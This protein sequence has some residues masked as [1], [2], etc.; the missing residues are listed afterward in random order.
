MIAESDWDDLLDS[1]EAGRVLPVLGW[2]ITTFGEQDQLLGPWLAQ[3]YAKRLRVDRSVLPAEFSVN[4]VVARHLVSKGRR[5]D[6]VPRFSDTVAMQD[7]GGLGGPGKSLLQLAEVLGLRLF[8]SLTPDSLMQQALDQVRH[9]GR[10]AT[11]VRRF[12]LQDTSEDLEVSLD[13]VSRRRSDTWVYHVLGRAAPQVGSCVIWDEDLLEFLLALNSSLERELLRNLYLALHPDQSVELLAIGVSFSDWVMRLFLRVMRQTPLTREQPA[14]RFVE[15]GSA[16]PAN[17]VLLCG[18]SVGGLQLLDMSPGEFVR[19][20]SE[21]WQRRHPVS[22]ELIPAAIAVPD[23]LPECAV[24][25]SY[26]REDQVAVAELVRRLQRRGCEVWLD[27][28]RLQSGM[29]FDM[30]IEDYIKKRRILFVSVISEQ[31]ELSGDAY[32]HKERTWAAEKASSIPEV[33]REEFYFPLIISE[34]LD[35]GRVQK[36]PRIFAGVHRERAAGGCVT[37]QFCDRLRGLQLKKLKRP[38]DVS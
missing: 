23:D 11:R 31:T 37:D 8:L 15:S 22:A 25:I 33:D 13:E 24:F 36:E 12:S 17:L 28:E 32:A 38:G 6:L 1:I 29:N 5:P 19:E 27:T 18:R 16:D 20:L 10:A 30:R 7:S 4:D 26:M 35:A 14:T 2:G 9:E 3:E 21:R 34:G